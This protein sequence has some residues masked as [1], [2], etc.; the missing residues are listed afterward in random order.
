M[1]QLLVVVSLSISMLLSACN[2]PPQVTPTALPTETPK[3]TQQKTNTPTP[4][5]EP[6]ATPQVFEMVP[7]DPVIGIPQGTDGL[8]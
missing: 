1:K 6:S 2:L 5:P 3:Q 8:P 7:V 4:T